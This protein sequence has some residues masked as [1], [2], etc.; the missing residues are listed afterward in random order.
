MT[1]WQGPRESATEWLT[2]HWLELATLGALAYPS[3]TGYL[4][5]PLLLLLIASALSAVLVVTVVIVWIIESRDRRLGISHGIEHAT[6]ALLERLV[7]F[8]LSGLSTHD[9]FV[10]RIARESVHLLWCERV[11]DAAQRAIDQL[12][13]GDR[14][15][16]YTPDCGTNRCA[17]DAMLCVCVFAFCAFA[18][19]VGAPP[20]VRHSSGGIGRTEGHAFPPTATCCGTAGR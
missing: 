1:W 18:Y 11:R 2:D 20:H 14:Q 9:S 15:L 8:S 13:A 17:E 3:L 10:V 6:I 5:L 7:G 16:A 4:K 19:V 12:A